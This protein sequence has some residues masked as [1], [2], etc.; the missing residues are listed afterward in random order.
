MME[1]VTSCRFKLRGAAGDSIFEGMSLAKQAWG[2]RCLTRNSGLTAMGYLWRRFGP[3][4][5]GSDP[6]KDLCSYW[7][8]TADPEVF[9]TLHLK[10]SGLA[11]GVSYL[12]RQSLHAEHYKRFQD[13]EDKFR[14]FWETQNPKLAKLK[15]TP[16]NRERTSEKY[17]DDRQNQEIIDELHEANHI[18]PNLLRGHHSS[19][20]QQIQ[21]HLQSYHRA[22]VFFLPFL[23]IG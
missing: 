22:V 16:K 6:H 17:F 4:V 2:K 3:P 9:L 7:L 13:W 11:Y 14:K 10:G 1:Q 12:A 20:D 18:Q 21:C 5:Y 19:L 23:A 8:T 15:D